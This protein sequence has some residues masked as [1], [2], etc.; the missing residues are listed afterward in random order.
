MPEN[1]LGPSLWFWNI[2]DRATR[3]RERLRK[4]LEG[5]GSKDLR[6]FDEEFQQ[7]MAELKDTPFLERI[8]A[9]QS[10][11]GIDDIAR[12]VVSQ[13]RAFY[14]EVRRHPEKIPRRLD[15]RKAEMLSGV[16]DAAHYARFGKGLP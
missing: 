16:A 3:S 14:F 6:R 11:D 2:V 10:E 8:D 9:D 12:W 15:S 5:F 7:A 1:G 4:L 13:G